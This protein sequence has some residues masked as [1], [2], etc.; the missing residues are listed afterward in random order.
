ME[1]FCKVELKFLC[2]QDCRCLFCSWGFRRGSLALQSPLY[3]F[4]CFLNLFRAEA[5]VF[6][7][8]HWPHTGK[9]GGSEHAIGSR[10]LQRGFTPGGGNWVCVLTGCV[11]TGNSALNL[12]EKHSS[13]VPHGRPFRPVSPLSLVKRM[14]L[15]A[16][17]KIWS[18]S[19]QLLIL[20][21][22]EGH[23]FEKKVVVCFFLIVSLSLYAAAWG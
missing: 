8:I 14:V 16:G 6:L 11:V 13:A 19:L 20:H 17:M 5:V 15:G 21:I 4:V 22:L 7:C 2:V 23:I 9:R 1:L 10:A 18:W 12:K 3:S